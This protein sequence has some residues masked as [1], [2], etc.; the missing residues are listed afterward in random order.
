[1]ALMQT[2]PLSI[3]VATESLLVVEDVAK[4]LREVIAWLDESPDELQVFNLPTFTRAIEKLSKSESAIRNSLRKASAGNPLTAQTLK[5]RAKVSTK[6][7][8]MIPGA[9]PISAK[10]LAEAEDRSAEYAA[11]A[12]EAST[13]TRKKSVK[14]KT[15]KPSE[16]KA[17]IES[18]KKTPKRRVKG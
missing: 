3:E 11:S 15:P 9:A 14:P 4:T 17:S 2:K 13:I 10:Q 5:P 8:P 12:V 16:V 1:M 6:S 18:A 7:P